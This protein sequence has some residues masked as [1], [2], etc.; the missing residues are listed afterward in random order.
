[1]KCLLV[2]ASLLFLS[3][4]SNVIDLTPENFEQYVDG[5]KHAFVEFFAPWCGHCKNLAP[6]YEEIADAFAKDKDSVVIAKVDADAH[7]EL[8]S[9]FGVTGFPTLKF[10]KKG[11]TDP[12][13]YNGGREAADIIE[14]VNKE[15]GTRARVNKP[16][17]AVTV[18][19]PSNFDSIVLDTSKYVF[20]EFYAPW[21]GHCKKLAPTWEKLA[22]VFK[23][24]KNVVIA[25]LDADAHKNLASKY[26]VSGFP[27]LLFFKGDDRTKG[28]K[29]NGGRELT[30]L[31][32]HINEQAGT[33]RLENG[34]YEET[35][36]RHDTLDAL[37][38]KFVNKDGDREKI[39]KEAEE[40]ATKLGDKNYEWYGKF[41]RVS[42]KRGDEFLSKEKERVSTLLSSGG[43][44]SSKLDEFT[45]RLNVLNAFN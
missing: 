12:T 16:P 35:V 22:N 44:E 3:T 17:T 31:V 23:N 9:K 43:V 19:T 28:E 14:F 38:K 42:L 6:A 18:L 2:L 30:D 45:V 33:K 7:K 24:E 34:N 21:C 41:M 8:A 1:M 40:E 39:A 25:N 37:A 15:A 20:A 10:F 4:C 11:S 32:K 36:G 29:Y 27:T 13:D 26:E 5:S